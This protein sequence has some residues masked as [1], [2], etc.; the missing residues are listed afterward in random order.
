MN[1][2]FELSGPINGQGLSPVKDMRYGIVDIARAGCGVIAVY[3]ALLL[4]GNPH[5]FPDVVAWGD[6]TAAAAFGLLGTLPWKAKHLFQRL[7]YTVTTV[8]DEA[9]FDRYAQ[10]ADVCLFTFWNQK[11][12]IR[13]GMHTVCLQYRS[14][15]ID[16]YNLSNSHARVSR[17]STLREWTASGIG[18]VVL[19]CIHK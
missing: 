2:Q 1:R 4:L 3:N 8:T 16:V 14:G 6:Q 17:K 10:D 11:G 5:R 7:G 9:L 15:A 13:Q 12:S 18:P 19:Y